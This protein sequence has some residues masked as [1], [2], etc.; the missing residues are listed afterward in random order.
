MLIGMPVRDKSPAP[1]FLG[2]VIDRSRLD[3]RVRQYPLERLASYVA[4]GERTFQRICG[5]A[6]NSPDP[7][8]LESGAV[9]CAPGDRL[10]VARAD[11]LFAKG[12][13]AASE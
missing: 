2:E 10:L 11:P 12:L 13:V 3:Q 1:L 7:C 4:G 8:G 9:E 5:I 6:A